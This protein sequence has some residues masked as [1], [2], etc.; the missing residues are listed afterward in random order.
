M[1]KRWSRLNDL[2]QRYKIGPL[3]SEIRAKGEI[4]LVTGCTVFVLREYGIEVS[5]VS[6]SK[7]VRMM[8]DSQ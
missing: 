1:F 7:K 4:V 8:D 5:V 2:W 3:F 6:L